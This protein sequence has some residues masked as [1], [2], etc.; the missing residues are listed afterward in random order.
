MEESQSTNGMSGALES[1]RR[2]GEV[3]EE[4]ARGCLELRDEA[5]PLLRGIELKFNPA[6]NVHTK[7]VGSGLVLSAGRKPAVAM[8]KHIPR[9]VARTG[10]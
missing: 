1:N 3:G 7:V 4:S 9:T 2:P 8:R 5:S 10:S 6:G